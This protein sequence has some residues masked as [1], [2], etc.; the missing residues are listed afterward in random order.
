M[1]QPQKPASAL[2][3]GRSVAPSS[4]QKIKNEWYPNSPMPWILCGG[5]R[6]TSKASD[7]WRKWRAIATSD[8]R[9]SSKR[10][11]EW[12]AS[13]SGASEPFSSVAAA[14]KAE[15]VGYS[16]KKAARQRCFVAPLE[17]R[18]IRQQQ[19]SS[20]HTSAQYHSCSSGAGD[21]GGGA[22]SRDVTYTSQ[23]SAFTASP[24]RRTASAR[25]PSAVAGAEPS[26]DVTKPASASRAS[27]RKRT[28]D[29][30]ICSRSAS[31][32]SSPPSSPGCS[33]AGWR[34]RGRFSARRSSSSPKASIFS[35]VYSGFSCRT[36]PL[37]RSVS[38]GGGGARFRF[39]F[40]FGAS[41]GSGSG[42]ARPRR[43]SSSWF[44]RMCSRRWSSY[45]LRD[46][47]VAI[48]SAA[49]VGKVST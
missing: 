48:F 8:L 24:H 44:R 17:T 13:R 4:R 22:L 23:S 47:M 25:Q 15:G 1:R 6:P 45:S 5:L 9:R 19:Q 12:I 36:R 16:A 11:S 29:A 10:P 46:S 34:W 40:G 28:V 2:S 18:D 26:S 3:F 32:S 31:S 27:R 43:T 35:C 39:A 37:R 33:H 38:G 41:D 49:I 14:R 20:R 21:V 42:S 30:S 7:E